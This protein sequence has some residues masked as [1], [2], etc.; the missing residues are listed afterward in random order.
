MQILQSDWQSLYCTIICSLSAI[1]INLRLALHH[2]C[3]SVITKCYSLPTCVLS[4]LAVFVRC[5]L[6]T[7]W[8]PLLGIFWSTC[9][10]LCQGM[11]DDGQAKN[12]LYCEIL[13]INFVMIMWCIISQDLK[14]N[15]RNCFSYCFQVVWR[16]LS[17]EPEQRQNGTHGHEEPEI[18]ED[19]L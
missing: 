1:G 14:F 10:G 2:K 11:Q 18:L 13:I 4:S 19:L 7:K 17:D 8:W 5:L 15:N 12:M 6:K 9:E 16:K 3:C